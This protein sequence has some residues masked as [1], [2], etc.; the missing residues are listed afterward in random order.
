M[1][2]SPRRFL[3]FLQ[4]H[5]SAEVLNNQQGTPSEKLVLGK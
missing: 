5:A 1:E 4:L 3:K 2:R